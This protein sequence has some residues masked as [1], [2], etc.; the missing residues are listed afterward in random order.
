MGQVT[1][2]FS[3]LPDP[4]SRAISLGKLSLYQK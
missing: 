4:S 3:E 2:G 1:V